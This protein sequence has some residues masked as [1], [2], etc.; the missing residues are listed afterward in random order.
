MDEICKKYKIQTTSN[1]ICL[2]DLANKIIQS[3][4]TDRYI[5]NI[6]QKKQIGNKYYVTKEKALSIIK[7]STSKECKKI[8]NEC[9]SPHAKESIV[10][11]FIGYNEYNERNEHKSYD[12]QNEHNSGEFTESDG[13]SEILSPFKFNGKS[14]KGLTDANLEYWFNGKKLSDMFE[15][16]SYPTDIFSQV[17]EENI[18]QGKNLNLPEY[19]DEIELTLDESV[20]Y[21]NESGIYE[22]VLCSSLPDA[23][24]FRQWLTQEVLQSLTNI[25]GYDGT[26]Y[27]SDQTKN[28][29]INPFDPDPI[30]S[31]VELSTEL[32]NQHAIIKHNMTEYE[33]QQD[34]VVDTKIK[35]VNDGILD[36]HYD[37]EFKKV[38]VEMYKLQIKEKELDLEYMK[39]LGTM[40]QNGI[41]VVFE[42]EGDIEEGGTAA[43]IPLIPM[44]LEAL[45]SDAI[46][47]PQTMSKMK[48]IMD[49]TIVQNANVPHK[50]D[51]ND[52]GYDSD[53]SI[54]MIE[55]YVSK[56]KHKKPKKPKKP[57]K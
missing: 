26:S 3:K 50:P 30:K 2:N 17:S 52:D 47:D 5:K 8:V 16:K 49:E 14:I 54:D 44:K 31:P 12:E 20:F 48:L 32:S 53:E 57:K 6:K 11:E 40:E 55:P 43:S 51:N 39:L 19:D 18:L 24:N 9:L 21:V 27:N 45:G 34:L 7:N 28:S 36:R 29:V 38:E 23:D 10:D 35:S 25:G 13:Y 22:L 41:T 37:L 15:L 42:D 33:P 4:N 46:S 56:K 1:Y